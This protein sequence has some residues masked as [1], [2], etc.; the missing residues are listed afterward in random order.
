MLQ[1][2]KTVRNLIGRA[3]FLAA[4]TLPKPWLERPARLDVGN[5]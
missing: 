1:R 3:T 2:K 5:L 4:K